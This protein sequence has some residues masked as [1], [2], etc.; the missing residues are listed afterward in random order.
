MRRVDHVLG[1]EE[2]TPGSVF[3]VLDRGHRFKVKVPEGARWGTTLRV[4]ELLV[5]LVRRPAPKVCDQASVTHVLLAEEAVERM[6]DLLVQSTRDS[7][8]LAGTCLVRAP[9]A[10]EVN[11]L[12][13]AD[14]ERIWVIEG[15]DTSERG[16][17]TSVQVP[18]PGNSPLDWHTHPGLKGGFAGFSKTDQ[19]SVKARRRPMVVIGYT[20]L[21]PQFIGVLTLP[22]GGW[23]LAASLGL[24]AAL[25]V[26][27][28][29]LQTEP[30]LLRVG[31]AGRVYFPNSRTEPIQLADAPGWRRAFDRASF[32]A[33]KVATRASQATEEVKDRLLL[34]LQKRLSR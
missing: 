26:E 9:A 31:A 27:A 33:D 5:R 2:L 34:E 28:R 12:E 24:T 17:A 6:V 19:A 30:R 32:E 25:Q 14:P 3:E 18:D 29:R 1:P 4:G 20:V 16:N 23:G 11:G 21:G 22:L 8:E 13:D 10:H 7:V 15:F